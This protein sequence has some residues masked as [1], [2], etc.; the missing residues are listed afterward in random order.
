MLC[1]QL[2]TDAIEN[3][4]SQFSFNN[5]ASLSWSVSA[6]AEAYVLPFCARL[7]DAT[8]DSGNAACVRGKTILLSGS[9]FFRE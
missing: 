6:C 3:T 8:R 9:G 4:I 2:Q 7:D 1:A 5:N